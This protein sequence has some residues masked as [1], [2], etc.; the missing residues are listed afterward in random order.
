MI[1]Q[2]TTKRIGRSDYDSSRSKAFLT[3]FVAVL[4]TFAIYREAINLP[5]FFDDMIHLRWLDWH[6]LSSLWT[7][8]EA[9]TYYRP[10]TFLV[11]KISYI[12]QHH[13]DSFVLH[14]VNMTLHALNG[15]LVSYLAYRLFDGER[16]LLYALA[17]ASLFVT[18]PFSYQ[19][20]PSVGSLSKPL[21]AFLVLS[22]GSLYC[23][24][25]RRG[26]R[27]LLFCSTVLAFLAPFAHENGV[28]VG[29]LLI[30]MEGL[31][32][33]RKNLGYT[34]RLSSLYSISALGFPIIWSTI[35][36]PIIWSMLPKSREAVRF[37]SL[38]SLW[39]NGVY[40]LQGLVFP[41]A[42]LAKI[43]M[44]I[45]PLNDF[46]ATALVTLFTLA[47]LFVL[48][49]RTK[50]M[51]LLFFSVGWFV[52]GVLPAWLFLKWDYV[53]DG[54]RL[55]YLA[56]V[57]SALLWAGVI[58]ALWSS[59]L[60][61]RLGPVLAGIVL[62]ILLWHN[63]A[64]IRYRME[65]YVL[66][67]DLLSQVTETAKNSVDDEPLLY[68]NIPAW[69]APKE[70]AYA[71]GHEGVTFIPSYVG[72]KDFVYV[73]SGLERKTYAVRF[74]NVEKHWRDYIG[75]YGPQVG[76]EDLCKAIRKA[77]VV[78]VTEYL[79]A[80]LRLVEAGALETKNGKLDKEDT[81][82]VFDNRMA[83]IK[84][85]FEHQDHELTVTFWWSCLDEIEGD[86][87]AFVHVYDSEGHLVAQ[88]DGYPLQG[89]F[90]FW[91]WREGYVVRDVRQIALSEDLPKGRY[92]L[93]VGV[94]DRNTGTRMRALDKG[95]LKYRDDAVPVLTFELLPT[96]MTIE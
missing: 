39:Q 37:A 14:L 8:A 47:L 7:T 88:R 73:N 77:N 21:L 28:L 83:L 92:V 64:F 42:P 90:P 69:L 79:P 32:L 10:L 16:R 20:V 72:V 70:S 58:S 22:C 76:W 82:A 51:Y 66:G 94:Y 2:W 46:G 40:F 31:G 1:W 45:L 74:A 61:R 24:A 34:S 71:L 41:V 19:S 89:L 43:L 85:S 11:W 75:C 48:F 54:P 44:R 86:Y 52:A 36:F 59:R 68:V 96:I 13:Y 91:L 9:F 30:A 6:S 87:T 60:F 57:G 67:A 27:F 38:Q 26:T 23:E 18:Y 15:V 80:R 95:G 35:G 65:L 53:I 50:R 49:R 17:A 4:L 25:R 12:I 5:F 78:Y 56:S 55:L 33:I 81:L 3:L 29:A 84:G 63:I 62:L 93:V